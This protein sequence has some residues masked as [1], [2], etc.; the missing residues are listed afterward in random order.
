M[1]VTAAL[2]Y[3]IMHKDTL[4]DHMIAL[5]ELQPKVPRNEFVETLEMLLK[6]LGNALEKFDFLCGLCCSPPSSKPTLV[7]SL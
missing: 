5:H 2:A 7:N 3:R 6:C 1:Q 4:F